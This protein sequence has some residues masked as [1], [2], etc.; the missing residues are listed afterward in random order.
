[1]SLKINF[2]LFQLLLSLF[3]CLNLDVFFL[4]VFCNLNRKAHIK[5]DMEKEIITETKC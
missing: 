4:L 2:I 1:M 3:F 5:K